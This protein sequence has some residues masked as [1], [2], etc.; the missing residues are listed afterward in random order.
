[1]QP[2]SAE[3]RDLNRQIALA[4]V[5]FLLLALVDLLELGP[6]AAA[7]A[8]LTLLLIYLA[9]AA[10]I[11]SL[12]YLDHWRPALFPLWADVFAVAAFLVLTPSVVAFWF[13][14]LFLA[15]AAAVR[16]G[17]KP[18]VI[19]AG[20]ATL[21]LPLRAVFTPGFHSPAMNSWLPLAAGTFAAGAGIG[22]LGARQRRQAVE[23]EALDRVSG[24]LRVEL[25]LA[26]SLRQMLQ[27][28]LILFDCELGVLAF[29]D[30]E[31]ERLFVWRVRRSDVQR[32]APENLPLEKSDAFLLDNLEAS[33]CWNSLAGSGDGF[34]WNSQDGKSL[35]A[36]PRLPGTSR[37]EMGIQ[38]MISTV[39]DF[40][41]QP[42]GRL[43]LCNCTA[44]FSR[45]DLRWLE[46]IVRHLSMPL[47]NLFL[48][49]HLRSRAIETERGRISRDL[50]DSIL[51][52]MLG[53]GIQLDVLHRKLPQ[54][55]EQVVGELS[56]LHQAVRREEEE[57]RKFVTDLRPVHV[58]SADLVDLMQG[59]AERFRSEANIKL[60]LIADTKDLQAPDRVCRELFQIYREALNNI[61]KHSRAT[62]VVVKLWQDEAKVCLAVDDNGQGFS[63]AGRFSSDEL[64]RL[65]LGP[66]SIKERARG[67]GAALT[68]ESSPGHGAKLVVEVPLS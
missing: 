37:E 62:H 9:L 14:Y 1:M 12:D 11:A 38:N 61:K 36:A 20:I 44:R 64:D 4:R 50:H 16:W 33:L 67:M 30:R 25:G 40:E 46:R 26:E 59:F 55:P 19:L 21:A 27:E 63:F 60:D 39:L 3:R 57:L 6:D 18:A 13:P 24:L 41:G 68:I 42:A 8:A 56:A 31:L 43:L 52:T 35:R 45:Q 17:M 29:H 54:A 66:I 47:E 58:E 7:P 49:R 15:F 28:F 23:N 34:A 22:F 48:L 32:L 10:L 5:I 2:H 53:L 51:Q 65:R